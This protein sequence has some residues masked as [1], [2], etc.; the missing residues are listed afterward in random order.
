[1]CSAWN[2]IVLE[3][4]ER[5]IEIELLCQTLVQWGTFCPD[6]HILPQRDKISALRLYLGRFLGACL[7]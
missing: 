2:H 1:M 6:Q 5:R 3:D 7:R 4:L